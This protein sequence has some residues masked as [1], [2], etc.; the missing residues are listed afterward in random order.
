MEME[1]RSKKWENTERS[2]TE[3]RDVEKGKTFK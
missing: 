2:E 1:V 3:E